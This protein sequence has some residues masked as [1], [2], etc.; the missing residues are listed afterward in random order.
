MVIILRFTGVK[1]SPVNKKNVPHS[2]FL[3]GVK[4]PALANAVRWL[5]G[6]YV[7]VYGSVHTRVCTCDR[8]RGAG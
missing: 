7:S 6:L 1:W 2:P 4:L 3:Y 5:S 8:E